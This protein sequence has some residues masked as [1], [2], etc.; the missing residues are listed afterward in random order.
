MNSLILACQFLPLLGLLLILVLGTSEKRI[1]TLSFWFTHAM[2]V[3]ILGLLATWAFHGFPAHEYLWLT[4]YHEADYHFHLLFYLDAVGA[5]YLFCTWVIFS[6]IVRYCRYYL[7]RETGYKR[8]FLT[9]FAFVFGLNLVILSGSLDMLFAGWEIVGIASFLLIAF[10]RTRQQPIRNALRAYSIYRFCDIGLLL[11]ALLGD[12][13][14]H[15]NNHFSELSSTLGHNALSGL[16]SVGLFTLSLFLLLAACGKSAQFPFCFWL[17]RAMEGPT[18]SSAIFYG[19]LS[20]HLGVFLLLRTRTIWEFELASRAI[21]IIIGLLTVIVASLSEKAQSSIKGQIAYSSIVQVGFM[22]ME[23]GFGLEALV[24]VH[25][26]GNAFLRCYQLLVSPSVVAHLLRVEGAADAGLTIK[27]PFMASSL[28]HVLRESLP[29]VLRNTLHV[30]ALQEFN[31]EVIVR[32]ILWAPLIRAGKAIDAIALWRKLT[33]GSAV[34]L[35]GGLLVETG[36][37]QRD[38]LAVP[39]ALGMFMASLSAFAEK[40]NVYRVWNA[41][42]LSGFL[43]GT[44]AWFASDTAGNGVDLFLGGV[45]PAWLIGWMTLLLILRGE[46]FAETPF[47]YRAMSVRKPALALTLFLCFLGLVSFPITPAFI[48]QDLLIFHVSHEYPWI[49][50]LFAFSFVLNGIAA[51]GVFQ[52]LT[53]GRPVEAGDT[54]CREDTVALWLTPRYWVTDAVPDK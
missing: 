32:G 1:A 6:V 24:L 28:P 31:L 27:N 36:W 3:S 18:P 2:G 29:D 49:V 12:L 11:G 37:L 45:I 19:A 51:A 25:F 21:V 5:T 35:I 13:L 39:M 23:L 15:G 50:V 16:N 43:A 14:F 30:C 20:V 41:V 52:R 9:I 10:Y 33:V 48:G 54:A 44:V 40:R 53:M 38:I 8:F 22:F 46:N 17:P 42:G 4:L 7:H 47:R 26:L 34:L